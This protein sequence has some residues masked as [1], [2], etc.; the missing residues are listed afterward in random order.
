ME[1]G[2]ARHVPPDPASSSESKH[3][4]QR[5]CPTTLILGPGGLKGY[6]EL[7]ALF[8]LEREGLLATIHRFV[9]VSVGAIIALLLAAGYSPQK[10]YENAIEIDLFKDFS[11]ITPQDIQRGAGLISNH[12]VNELLRRLLIARFGFVPTLKQLYLATGMEFEAVAV[13]LAGETNVIYLS[14]QT[15]PELLAVDAALLSSNIPIVFHRA[16]HRGA[17]IIDGALGNPYPVDVYDDG[18]TDILGIYV[19]SYSSTDASPAS[20]LMD[21]LKAVHA[22]MLQLKKRTEGRASPRVKHLNLHSPVD[23]TGLIT[24][25]IEDKA[26]MLVGG[27]EGAKRF[28]A[29]LRQEEEEEEEERDRRVTP[30]R[31]KGR[32][33]RREGSATSS[34]QTSEDHHN[35]EQNWE[36]E[37]EDSESEEEWNDDERS[38]R[39]TKEIVVAPLMGI[40]ATMQASLSSS[41][42]EEQ[43]E[44]SE[45]SVEGPER[46]MV[47]RTKEKDSRTSTTSTRRRPTDERRQQLIVERNFKERSNERDEKGKEKEIA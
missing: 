16:Y 6:V 35:R 5:W 12:Q 44:W 17:V 32:T 43:S 33:K 19:T 7:G 25:P 34:T 11:S 8:I 45:R 15:D 2:D 36:E 18:Q 38:D 9:G 1:K 41:E 20:M 40:L 46:R 24:L 4:L 3:P 31:S 23:L 30:E 47:V 14:H 42:L 10:I 27:Y 21:L 13:S 28:I 39:G 29:E 26:R 22:T 37:Q